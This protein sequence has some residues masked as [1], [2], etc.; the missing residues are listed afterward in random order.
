MRHSLYSDKSRKLSDKIQLA[1]NNKLKPHF[2]WLTQNSMLHQHRVLGNVNEHWN[3]TWVLKIANSFKQ[4]RVS[5]SHLTWNRTP[6]QSFTILAPLCKQN[7]S[8]K[9]PVWIRTLWSIKKFKVCRSVKC[10]FLIGGA[11][12]IFTDGWIGKDWNNSYGSEVGK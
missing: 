10:P 3:R 4:L 12:T 2:F 8:A 6:C 5:E 1:L 9:G 11:Y 7:S